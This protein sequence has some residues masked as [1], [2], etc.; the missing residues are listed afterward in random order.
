[1]KEIFGGCWI[2]QEVNNQG[3]ALLTNAIDIT[4]G[5]WVLCRPVVQISNEEMARGGLS[6]VLEHAEGVP[7]FDPRDRPPLVEQIPYEELLRIKRKHSL[8]TVTLTREATLT[9]TIVPLHAGRGWRFNSHAE[10]VLL[11]PLP[12]ANEVFVKR[13]AEALD[14]AD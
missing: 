7:E 8:V 4:R 3:Y 10:E 11:I 6:I 9:M 13:L 14:M 12:T 2:G 1:M 5:M